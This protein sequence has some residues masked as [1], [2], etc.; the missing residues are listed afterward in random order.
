MFDAPVTAHLEIAQAP[1]GLAVSAFVS[2]APVP[3]LRWRLN[4]TSTNPGGTSNVTQGGAVSGDAA[5][6]LG[7]V[8]ISPNSQGTVT[9]TVLDGEREVARDVVKFGADAKTP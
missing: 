4:L 2:A 5:K 8:T 7:S 1:Q 9:L 6:P 3:A